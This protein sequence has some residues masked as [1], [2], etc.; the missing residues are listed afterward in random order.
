VRNISSSTEASPSRGLAVSAGL[1]PWSACAC[2]NSSRW[3]AVR[4]YSYA[5]QFT[6]YQLAAL[7]GHRALGAN[8]T[9]NNNGVDIV[10]HGPIIGFSVGL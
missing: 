7:I 8:Y 5:W 6:G 4:V 10:L 9:N 2:A 1:T 3:Q